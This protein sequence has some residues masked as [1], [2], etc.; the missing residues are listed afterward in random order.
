MKW[1]GSELNKISRLYTIATVVGSLDFSRSLFMVY[2]LAQGL[3]SKELGI[4][5][6]LLFWTSFIFE[7]P[8]GIVADRFGR[9]TSVL[10]GYGALAVTFT[11]LSSVTTFT[12]GLMTFF[13]WGIAFAFVSGANSAFLY[14]GLR[15]AGV[16]EKHIKVMVRVRSLNTIAMAVAI[17]LGGF[18]YAW[19]ASSIFWISA[20]CATT[21][22]ILFLPLPEPR[23][24]RGLTVSHL[25]RALHQFFMSPRG[26]NLMIFM[27]A[28]SLIEMMSTPFYIFSQLSFSAAGWS[29]EQIGALMGAGF[30]V[31]ALA[32]WAAPRFQRATPRL[33]VVIVALIL[34][35]L[36]WVN[37]AFESSL[38]R[39]T[40]FFLVNGISAFL[41]VHSDQYILDHCESSIRASLLSVQSFLNAVM[42]GLSY[43][44]IGRVG[45]IL[46]MSTG[47]SLLG[48]PV[49]FSVVMIVWHARRCSE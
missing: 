25:C 24:D 32:Q 19:H 29:S 48:L 30:L 28:M 5:Q 33:H 44:L 49:L 43:I 18:L 39:V 40:V 34:T 10:L 15:E 46:P 21:G 42:I 4:L 31:S 9:K 13:L 20:I 6:A 17:L 23:V 16:I 7:V 12:S 27:V 36:L 47:L 14:D 35:G 45:E 37:W 3:S 41:F 11:L 2:L 8:T 26:R 1:D 38:I 22:L